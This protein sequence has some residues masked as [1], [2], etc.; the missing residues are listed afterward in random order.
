MRIEAVL[1]CGL[2]LGVITTAHAQT[3][4][5]GKA[6][7]AKPDPNYITPVGDRA[8]HVM[9]LSKTICTWTQG[10]VA[11]IL[12]KGEEDTGVWDISGNTARNHGYSVAT[13]ANGDKSFVRFEGTATFKDSAPVRDHGTWNFMGGTGKLKGVKGKG[14]YQVTFNADGTS[15]L[16]VEG[17]Y[18][19]PTSTSGK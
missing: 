5:S 16:D 7:C 13:L 17:E 2:V 9:S 12:V 11:G 8:D 6:Q 14:T 10:E 15:M 3:K 4:F 19:L 18:Q 1:V